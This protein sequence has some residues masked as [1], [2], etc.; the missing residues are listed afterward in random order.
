MVRCGA[1][2]NLVRPWHAGRKQDG[3][4]SVIVCRTGRMAEAAGRESA[5]GAD[6]EVVG[7]GRG[8]LS[9]GDEPERGRNGRRFGGGLAMF[10]R[11]HP[12]ALMTT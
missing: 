4:D 1:S 2:R 10:G 7:N 12:Q 9:V 5:G 11:W 8:G 6:R 3:N